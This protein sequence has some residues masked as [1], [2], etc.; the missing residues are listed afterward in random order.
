MTVAYRSDGELG[1]FLESAAAAS[2]DPVLMVVAD[3]L[4][5]V[6]G[7]ARIAAGHGATYLPMT[8]NLGYG[9]AINAAADTL[10]DSVEWILISNPDVVLEPGALDVL[11]ARAAGDRRIGSVG[12]R[13]LN[14]DG[15]I[16][17][18]ARAIPSIRFG[19]GHALFSRVWAGNPWTRRYHAADA[20]GIS[21]EAGWLSGACLLVRRTAF[22]GIRGFDE[23]FFMYF[24]DVDLGFR[25]G[26]AGWTNVYE[27]ATSATH[28]GARSTSTESAAMITAHHRSAERFLAKRYSSPWLA[29]VRL[30]LLAG[31]RLRA[32]VATK[33]R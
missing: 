25:L 10:P 2:L 21:R 12:P 31:L 8:A 17:P 18:S 7:A 23:E 4:P 11:I 13:I 24:E 15:T 9:G 1:E 27:P 19:I 20:A 30:V 3:N 6:G 29:P 28:H 32:A 26:R 22:E 14:E 16:Y 33:S 5:S